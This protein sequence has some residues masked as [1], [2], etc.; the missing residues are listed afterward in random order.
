MY[1]KELGGFPAQRARRGGGEQ[2]AAKPSPKDAPRAHP[3][4]GGSDREGAVWNTH[5]KPTQ[6]PPLRQPH[7]TSTPL[8]ALQLKAR[9]PPIITH[10]APP[11]PAP[12][13]HP[14]PQKGGR[15]TWGGVCHPPGAGMG[16]ERDRERTAQPSPSTRELFQPAG[17][18]DCSGGSSS[19]NSSE[20]E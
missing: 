14:K 7:L 5:P 18:R 2:E 1:I 11:I 15:Q 8:P 6:T 4:W 17:D 13:Q 19:A 20:W 10:P 16:R 3:C 9:H 12:Q